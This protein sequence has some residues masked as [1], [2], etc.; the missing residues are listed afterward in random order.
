M[1]THP[2]EGQGQALDA[3]LECLEN[4]RFW[5]VLEP[6]MANVFRETVQIITS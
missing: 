4:E 1:V 6:A 5:Q 2:E 3:L